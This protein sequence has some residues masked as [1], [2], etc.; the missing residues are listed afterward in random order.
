[1]NGNRIAWRALSIAAV[2]KHGYRRAA[3]SSL[4]GLVALLDRRTE[5]G[6]TCHQPAAQAGPLR[7]L[8]RKDKGDLATAAVPRSDG[9]LLIGLGRES[10]KSGA[11]FLP[12]PAH[13]GTSVAVVDAAGARTP[14]CVR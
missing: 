5:H 12:V 3:D 6:L 1:M 2:A 10:Q 4:R 11:E 8:L 14:A 9:G 7:A 13:Y